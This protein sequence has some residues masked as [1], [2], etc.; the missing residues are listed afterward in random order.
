MHTIIAIFFVF[1]ISSLSITHFHPSHFLQKGGNH[2][3]LYQGGRV[4]QLKSATEPEAQVGIVVKT[5]P[6]LGVAN[7]FTVNRVG[8]GT[9]LMKSVPFDQL[10]P[11]PSVKYLEN[12]EK[13]RGWLERRN[14]KREE[15]M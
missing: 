13:L 2:D 5:D 4:L 8:G 1:G 3:Q 11:I 14:V 10:I 6:L 9:T 7:F 12:E 15:K